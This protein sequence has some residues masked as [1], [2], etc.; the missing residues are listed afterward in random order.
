MKKL[1]AG[2]H[3]CIPKP[4]SG[5]HSKQQFSCQC[6]LRCYNHPSTPTWLMG[7]ATDGFYC[8][9]G[10][11]VLLVLQRSLFPATQSTCRVLLCFSGWMINKK[12]GSVFDM[13]VLL[14]F[15]RRKLEAECSGL[16]EHILAVWC[17]IIGCQI[18]GAAVRFLRQMQEQSTHFTMVGKWEQLIAAV[19]SQSVKHGAFD[20]FK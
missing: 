7:W 20:S 18:S 9:V 19:L 10:R 17:F 15:A 2:L 4:T 14:W 6:F 16:S 5:G 3:H 1:S 8:L 12:C 13:K 11:T